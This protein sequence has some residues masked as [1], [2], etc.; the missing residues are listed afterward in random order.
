MCSLLATSTP[1]TFP[2]GSFQ[3][4]LRLRVL[5][6]WGPLGMGAGVL[7]VQKHQVLRPRVLEG[8]SWRRGDA[9]MERAEAEQEEEVGPCRDEGASF[10]HPPSPQSRNSLQVT[11]KA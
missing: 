7:C 9:E 3:A 2:A 8:R 1:Y 5:G 11:P 10:S 4:Q 6:K